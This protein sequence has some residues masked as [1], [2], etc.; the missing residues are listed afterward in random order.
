M[1]FREYVLKENDD[2]WLELKKKFSY[3]PSI[4][5]TEEL[6][7]KWVELKKD[8]TD[9]KE[10]FQAWVKERTWS[11]EDKDNVAKFFFAWKGI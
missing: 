2:R 3:E 7:D 9:A 10:K 1:K 8:L 6:N 4:E 5:E 11:T